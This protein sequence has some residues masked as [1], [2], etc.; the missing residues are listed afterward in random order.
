MGREVGRLTWRH[1]GKLRAS[2]G[3]RRG[4]ERSKGQHPLMGGGWV[5]D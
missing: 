3:L 5:K 2:E 4:L 1:M